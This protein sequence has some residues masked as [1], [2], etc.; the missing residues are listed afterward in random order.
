MQQVTRLTPTEFEEEPAAVLETS[1]QSPFPCGPHT[2]TSLGDVVLVDGRRTVFAWHA[3]LA[4]L[5]IW[6]RSYRGRRT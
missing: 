5:A 3:F 1:A 6:A 2:L 4:F